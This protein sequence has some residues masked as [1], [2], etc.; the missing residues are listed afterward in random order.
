METTE[1]PIIKRL[2]EVGETPFQVI[3]EFE[4]ILQGWDAK[5]RR[6]V[7]LFKTVNDKWGYFSKESKQIMEV[8]AW[9][10]KAAFIDGNWVKMSLYHRVLVKFSQPVNSTSWDSSN[11]RKTIV[12]LLEAIIILTDT[13]YKSLIEQMQ[14]RQS[15][16]WFKLS[17]MTKKKSGGGLMTYANKVIWVS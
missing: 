14:G 6:T 1:F 5:K 16:S 7:Y 10:K 9:D 15:G 13:A 11:K 12:P 17:F 4:K 2:S 3:K 8:T